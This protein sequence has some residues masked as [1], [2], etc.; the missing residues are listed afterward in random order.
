MASLSTQQSAR[1]QS[2]FQARRERQR[3]EARSAILAAAEALLLE[4]GGPEFSMRSLGRRCG[5]SAPTVYHYFG[6]KDGLIDALLEA[7]MSRLADR[8]DGVPRG[9]DPGAELRDLFVAFVEFGAVNPSFSRLMQ[10][11]SSKGES[12]SAPAM[13]RVRERVRVPL[14]ELVESGRLGDL[15]AEAAGQMLWALL[16]GLMWLP[17]LEP[18]VP[19][20][21]DLPGRAFSSLLRGMSAS[22][23]PLES[24]R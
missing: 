19:W 15:D 7:R 24:P 5:Y 3:S 8:L 6:D 11:V 4:K 2:G 10:S 14:Q 23:A 1:R 22:A 17:V 18:E 9:R 21:S 12:H 16:H 13:E 20:V